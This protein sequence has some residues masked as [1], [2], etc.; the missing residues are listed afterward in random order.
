ML[1]FTSDE[2]IMWNVCPFQNTAKLQN[3]RLRFPLAALEIYLGSNFIPFPSLQ[4]KQDIISSNYR[5]VKENQ[6]D[7]IERKIPQVPI[8]LREILLDSG[9]EKKFIIISEY[10]L[11]Y[12]KEI[13]C[14][15]DLEPESAANEGTTRDYDVTKISFN[16]RFL[17]VPFS[18]KIG[19]CRNSASNWL[20]LINIG[21]DAI[22]QFSH[23][24]FS[25]ENNMHFFC[26]NDENFIVYTVNEEL[27]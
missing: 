6:Y 2:A 23:I 18:S 25:Y 12:F 8:E 24:L 21:M 7:L 3:Q 13:I 22:A 1:I 9:N 19:F 16:F 15:V 14:D 10:Y 20:T 5:H 4:N 11:N 27:P 26:T 17:N